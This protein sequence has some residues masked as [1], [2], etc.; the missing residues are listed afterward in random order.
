LYF[1]FSHI[2]WNELYKKKWTKRNQK[3]EKWGKVKVLENKQSASSMN[4]C[5]DLVIKQG[6]RMKISFFVRSQ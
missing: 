4:M 3:G 5:C 1:T 2:A 6:L